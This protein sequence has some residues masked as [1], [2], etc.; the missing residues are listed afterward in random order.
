M[1]RVWAAAVILGAVELISCGGGRSE[2]KPAQSAERV[3]DQASVK[4]TQFYATRPRLSRGEKSDLCYGV[5]NAK[6]V[7][8][9][10]AVADVWPTISRCVE[11]APSATTIYTLTA[12]DG[13]GRSATQTAKVEVGPPGPKIIEVTVNKQSISAGEQVTICYQARNVTDATISPGEFKRPPDPNR[14]CITDR[15][16]QTT[17]YHVKVTGAGGQADTEKVTVAVK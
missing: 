17:T 15:P 3:A 13:Q 4:I 2:P 6:S 10:P 8:V 5:E 14:G 1:G 16:K 7:R 9:S 11:V 12:E